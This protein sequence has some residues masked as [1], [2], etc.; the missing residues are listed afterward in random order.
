MKKTFTRLLMLTMLTMMSG[1]ASA[2]SVTFN[3][4][5]WDDTNKKVVTTQQT[6]DGQLLEIRMT[7]HLLAGSDIITTIT[8]AGGEGSIGVDYGG[9]GSGP[10]HTR[11]LD[12]LLFDF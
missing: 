3:V 8:T 1:W 5:S 6:K 2:E 12:D 11:E 9:G 10:A 4:R 7:Q